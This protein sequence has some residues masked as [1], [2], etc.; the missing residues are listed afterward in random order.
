MAQRYPTYDS[1]NRASLARPVNVDRADLR[2]QAKGASAMAQSANQ[3]MNFAFGKLEQKAKLEGQQYGAM[4]PQKAMKQSKGQDTVFDQYAYG[5]AVKVASA[6]IETEARNE[7]GKVLLEWKNNK[8]DPELLRTK[9]D[10]INAGFSN[11]LGNMD[12]LSA[13]TLNETLTRLS[14]SVYL[15]YT[16]DWMKDQKDDLRTATYLGVDERLNNIE[17]MGRQNITLEQFNDN[18]NAEIASLMGFMEGSDLTQKEISAAVINMRIRANKARVRGGFERATDK[19]AFAEE[20]KND[21]D[22]RQGLASGLDEAS[23]KTLYGEMNTK[24]NSIDKRTTALHKSLDGKFSKIEEI[25]VDGLNPGSQLT[26]LKKEAEAAGYGDLYMEI[27]QLEY[28]YENYYRPARLKS[29]EELQIII[30]EMQKTETASEEVLPEQK[31]IVENLEKI[32]ADI[33]SDR[34]DEEADLSN[35]FSSIEKIVSKGRNP[36]FNHLEKLLADAEEVG[37]Q[38]MIEKTTMLINSTKVLQRANDMSAEALQGEI[39]DIQ[40]S[41]NNS[42][43]VSEY[44]QDLLINLQNILDRKETERADEDAKLTEMMEVLSQGY[45]LNDELQKELSDILTR[46]KDDEIRDKLATVIS[47]VTQL[48]AA[49][50]MS[51]IELGRV[52]DSIDKVLQKKGADEDALKLVEGLQSLKKNMINAL[53]S[54]P[55]GW[56]KKTREDFPEIAFTDDGNMDAQSVKNRIEWVNGWSAEMNITPQYLTQDESTALINAFSRADLNNK[57]VLINRVRENF[58]INTSAVWEQIHS[59]G[60]IGQNLAHLGTLSFYGNQDIVKDSLQGLEYDKEQVKEFFIEAGTTSS[61]MNEKIMTY[62]GGTYFPGNLIGNIQEVTKSAYKQRHI[63]LKKDEFDPELFEQTFQ[64]V[65]GAIYINGEK[66]GGIIEFDPEQSGTEHNLMIP[67][68]IWAEGFPGLIEDMN[69][70]DF[71]ANNNNQRLHY[72]RNGQVVQFDTTD[73]D[74]EKFNKLKER[75]HFTNANAD[76]VMISFYPAFSSDPQ[77]LLDANGDPILLN[78]RGLQE[79]VAKRRAANSNS[80]NR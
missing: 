12:S 57:I 13:A 51:V 30:N 76:E 34:V 11:A 70:V 60:K 77:Y 16:E 78:L 46:Y 24:I 59:N 66:Y 68:N 61:E 21:F 10:N 75:F 71:L 72:V 47:Q 18:L 62:I 2:E 31:E 23:Q 33:R 40:A 42:D 26:E 54:D 73:L 6:Q 20:F 38:E 29:P 64:E 55:I 28:N 67:N 7:M 39:N 22:K 80:W 35:R 17:L 53:E 1:S 25:V 4:N 44:Q 43:E 49:E 63:N 15:D 14:N 74:G 9:L 32:L 27:E 19:I 37:D 50:D 48:D 5:A 8:A 36:G 45:P 56:A 69:E 3:I 52:I 41:I 58:D 79:T 65:A